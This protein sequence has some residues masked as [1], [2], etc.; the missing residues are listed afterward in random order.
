VFDS[1]KYCDKK[2]PV[3][4]RHD[5]IRSKFETLMVGSVRV[6]ARADRGQIFVGFARLSLVFILL[7]VPRANLLLSW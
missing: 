6:C 2:F 3:A 1:A 5:K 7:Y 4:L